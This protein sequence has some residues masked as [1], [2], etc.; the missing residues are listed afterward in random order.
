M[1]RVIRENIPSFAAILG[2]VAIAAVVGG[3]IL[4]EQR[5]RFPFI[6]DEPARYEIVFSNAQAVTPGQ[7]QSIQVSGVQIGLIGDVRLE[8]GRAIVGVDIEP[9]YADLI[10]EDARALLR[11]RTGLKDMY[12]QLFPGSPD[13]PRAAEGFTIPVA[14]TLTDV[15]L[16]EIL[17]SLDERTRDYVKLLVQGTGEGLK[18]RG[19]DVAEVFRRFAPT[20]RDLGR[21]NRAVARERVSLRRLITSMARLNERLARNPEDLSQLVDT[22]AATFRAFA[23]EDDNLRATISELAPTLEQTNTTL[24][25][26]LPFA[27]ELEPA[28]RRLVPTMRALDEANR[29]V[30]PAART[31]TPIVRDPIRPFVRESRPVVRDLAP[32]AE[33]LADV[34]PELTR[35][36]GVLNRFFN[37]LAHNPRGRED[38]NQPNREE[39]YLFWLAWVG[40]QTVNLI[41]TDDANGPMRPVFLTGTCTTLQT[42]IET[43]G[44]N[45]PVMEFGFNLSALFANIC[46]NEDGP[47]VSLDELLKILPPDLVAL[48]P[49]PT[50]EKVDK[51]ASKKIDATLAKARAK[52]K[53]G[54]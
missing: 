40:H 23:S 1:K 54:R 22:S 7:G 45:A 53:A 42:F 28:T 24:R 33:S 30:R 10:K 41:N 2:L 4:N 8:E 17:N 49:K 11:P 26:V 29:E 15:D 19:S 43:E 51:D 25:Q 39:G 3:Y 52:T 37:M 32:A 46:G 6:E 48:L 35:D 9:R 20:L 27:R 18:D 14:N 36:L 50:L 38:A 12:I 16:D 47:S 21:V 31:I 44:F 34:S 5:L 13:A